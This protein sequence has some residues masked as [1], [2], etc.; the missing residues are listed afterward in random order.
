[1]TLAVPLN[2]GVLGPGR[3]QRPRSRG[4]DDPWGA[5]AVLQPDR[6]VAVPPVEVGGAQQPRHVLA[7]TDAAHPPV[8][9]RRRGR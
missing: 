9:A 7:V 5:A 2:A 6:A 8:L 3:A 4:V 1:M